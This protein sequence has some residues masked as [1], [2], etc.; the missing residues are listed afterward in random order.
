MWRRGTWNRL[1]CRE[2]KDITVLHGRGKGKKERK[3]ERKERKKREIKAVTAGIVVWAMQGE[4]RL[5]CDSDLSCTIRLNRLFTR[6]TV[7]HAVRTYLLALTHISFI[8]LNIP[9]DHSTDSRH[10]GKKSPAQILTWP[11]NTHIVFEV[12]VHNSTCCTHTHT[13]TESVCAATIISKF[14]I[15]QPVLSRS[16]Y[17]M[18]KAAENNGADRQL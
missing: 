15:F 16:C 1:Q 3:R 9:R 14:F 7:I 12:A 10:E 8:Q 2:E 6:W 18:S 11:L 17:I 4:C 13:H 5:K